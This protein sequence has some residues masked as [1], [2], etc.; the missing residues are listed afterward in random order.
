MAVRDS[1]VMQ[2][3]ALVQAGRKPEALL[4]LNQLGAAGH[5]EALRILGE[6]HWGSQV[7]P[8]PAAGR[9]LFERAATA[10]DATA[11][12]YVTNLLAS[13]IAGPRDWQRAL[14]R[15]AAEAKLD[16]SRRQTLDLIARMKLDA[17]G[18]PE[19]LRPGEQVSERPE[20]T[21]HAGLFTAAECAY[22]LAVAQP[23][24]APS[25]VYDSQRRL[26]RDP[27]RSSDGS[28]LHWLIEDPAIHALNRRL[29]AA[30][31]TDAS[32]GEA[33]QVLRYKPGQEYRPH[34]DFV[35][36]APNQRILTALVWLN[37]DYKGGETAFLKA[38]LK[39]KGRKGDAVV[40]RNALP[41]GSIDPL[42]EHAGLPVTAGV[43]FL[44]S[45]WIRERRW[46]P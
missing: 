36:A 21:R 23:G 18:N 1:R 10:G 33:A 15:L 7:D 28:T 30:C 35:R 31:G 6:L 34:F 17:S 11:A 29:A 25:T 22:V 37:H 8:D 40:F 39:L 24:Y 9:A 14:V 3:L 43:K 13:G 42:T 45:R 38:G 26:V 44:Y 32:Q 41:D 2:A 46:A 5:G 12:I 4:A 16:A 27:I 20:I 19:R